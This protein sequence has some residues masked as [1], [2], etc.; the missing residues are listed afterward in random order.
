MQLLQNTH[1]TS[2]LYPHFSNFFPVA[3][4]PSNNLLTKIFDIHLYTTLQQEIGLNS[5]IYEE[6]CFLGTSVRMVALTSLSK[7]P[8]LKKDWIASTIRIAF[9]LSSIVFL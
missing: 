1:N 6:F 5:P 2:P 9:N 8:D 3:T 7:F 4:K